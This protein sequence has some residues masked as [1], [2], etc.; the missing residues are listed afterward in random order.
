MEKPAPEFCDETNPI[1][2]EDPDGEKNLRCGLPATHAGDHQDVREVLAEKL[3]DLFALYQHWQDYDGDA[4]SFLGWVSDEVN[5]AE[6]KFLADAKKKKLGPE[7]PAPVEGEVFADVCWVRVD[8]E[9]GPSVLLE[10]DRDSHRFRL[11]LSD[12]FGK[13]LSRAVGRRRGET[14]N[15]AGSDERPRVRLSIRLVRR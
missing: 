4:D 13:A 14:R 5:D 8:P 6:K 7:A 11:C 9:D 2:A 15:A 1:L 3:D 12:E 10:D